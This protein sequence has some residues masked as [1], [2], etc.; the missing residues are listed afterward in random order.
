LTVISGAGLLPSAS[1]AQWWSSAPVDFEQC[2]E[3]AATSSASK[4]ARG[5]LL[6]QCES[7]F[8]GRRKPG[9]GYSYY[10]FMQNRHFDIAGPNPTEAELKQIDQHYTAFLEQ[11]RRGLIL[12]A[13]AAKQLQQAQEQLNQQQQQQQQQKQ[14]RPKPAPAG[15]Q[16]TAALAPPPLPLPR[17]TPM[18]CRNDALSC[19][20]MHLSSGL[21]NFK[22][23]LLGQPGKKASRSR[24]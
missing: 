24:S 4:D 9:G 5:A 11:Q 19:G 6:A 7:K 16:R 10:D 20:W 22:K 15:K 23:S 13:F 12:A 8:A 1:Q 14:P 18:H 17:P 3:Q 2:A 21:D